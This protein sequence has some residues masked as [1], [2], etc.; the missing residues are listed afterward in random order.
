M[1]VQDAEGPWNGIQCYRNEGWDTFEWVDASGLPYPN[2]PAEGDEVTLS[3]TVESFSGGTQ[4]GSVSL[5]MVHGPAAQMI[6]P[7]IVSIGDLGEAYEGCL[8]ALESIHVDSENPD[9]PGGD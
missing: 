8:V 3:G 1:F 9:A 2:G 4:L 7:S 5:G 6:T